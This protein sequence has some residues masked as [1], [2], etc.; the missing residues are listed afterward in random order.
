MGWAGP[1]AGHVLAALGADVIK[2]ESHTHFD[3]W[4]GSRPPG[5]GAG[6]GLHERSHVFN[7][8]N[9][10]KRGITV[11]LA[12]PRGNQ[13]ARELIHDADVV[14]EN[15]GAGIIEKLGLTYEALSA[16]NPGLI[17]LRQPGFGSTGPEAGYVA[18]G[19]TIEG[20]S[21]LTALVGYENEGPPYMLSNALGDPISGFTG[22]AAILA[23]M[24]AR[25]ADGR[26][27]LVECAQLEGF[28]PFTSEALIECQR[29]GTQ[30]AR[31][32]NTR[33]GRTPSGVYRCA[34]DDEWIAVEVRSD[35]EWEAL[36]GAL[37][38]PWAIA[39]GLNTQEE[40]ARAPQL[41]R[42]LRAWFAGQDRDAVLAR[43]VA[44]GVPAAPVLSEPGVLALEPLA[45]SGFWVGEDRE[46][47][48]FHLYPSL[49]IIASGVHF[50]VGGPAPQLGEHTEEVLRGMGLGDSELAELESAGVTGS[51]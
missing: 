36:A 22:A 40:R 25:K 6:L 31:A 23:A 15:F 30:P 21:G 50:E 29:T 4:R 10:G 39:I 27:R 44:A 5:D 8:V 37:V 48:G 19:N 24:H 43:L 32:G 20:M 9:R 18:F 3:W 14:I 13:L 42:E 34:G 11:N 7:A 35:A 47:V 49:P 41:E 2:V 12:T 45:A 1:L 33:P 17:M 38:E 26:G 28:L 16:E 46:P 51:V